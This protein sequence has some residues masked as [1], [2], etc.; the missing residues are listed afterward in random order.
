MLKYKECIATD[1]DNRSGFV[2]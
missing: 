2:E 1:E